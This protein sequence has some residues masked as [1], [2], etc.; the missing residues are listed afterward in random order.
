MKN[1]LNCHVIGLH[2]FPISYVN[3]LY[4][5]VFYADTNHELWKDFAIAIHPHHVD[6]KITILDGVLTN[7]T[8]K[9]LD[10]ADKGII[11]NEYKWNSHILNGNGGFEFIDT[12]ILRHGSNLK[13]SKGESFIL[14]ACE[15]HT[16]FVEKG[17]ACC[18]IVEESKPTC[19]YFP[20]TYS[21][22]DLTK[23][24]TEG[25]YQECGAITKDFYL[26]KYKHLL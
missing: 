14:K 22:N 25:L 5:R 20:L 6:I 21:M 26:S 17:K 4:K 18:W 9:K 10:K 2:S 1:Y 16:V 15:L 13:Y 24:N 23:W 3:G 8:Y 7:K 12:A 19:E 11:I